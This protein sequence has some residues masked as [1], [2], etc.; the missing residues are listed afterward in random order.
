RGAD[1]RATGEVGLVRPGSDDAPRENTSVTGEDLQRERGV[2]ERTEIR[3]AY[4]EDWSVQHAREIRDGAPLLV[5]AHEETAGTFDDHKP[6]AFGKL[7]DSLGRRRA[8]EC[9][10]LRVP[11]GSGWRGGARYTATLVGA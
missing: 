8:L 4:D 3:S 10:S 5:V 9:W 2:V 11:R 1:V 6:A 7:S